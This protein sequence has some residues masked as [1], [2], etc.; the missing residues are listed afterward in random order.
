MRPIEDYADEVDVLA[1]EV[2]D[3][4]AEN[5]RVGSAHGL[6]DDFKILFDKAFKYR[7]A[8][9]IAESRRNLHILT[10][11]EAVKQQIA[12]QVFAEVY[13]IYW[14]NHKAASVV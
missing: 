6:D 3:T 14:T 2:V 12:L 10:P 4:W 1:Q 9:I 5:L 8:R 11:T 13:K 7:Q